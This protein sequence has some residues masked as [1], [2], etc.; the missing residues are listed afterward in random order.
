M[1]RLL[2][3][4]SLAFPIAAQDD[5]AA[6]LMNQAGGTSANPASNRRHV[7]FN[8]GSWHLMVHAMASL[9]DLQASGPMRVGA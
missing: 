2:L 5:A 9:N 7:M 4:L 6:L 8:A 1:K 3:L